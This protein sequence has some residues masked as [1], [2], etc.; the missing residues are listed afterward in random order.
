M[1]REPRIEMVGVTDD[2]RRK[3][4][5]GMAMSIAR[6]VLGKYGLAVDSAVRRKHLD[7]SVHRAQNPA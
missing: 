4:R 7:N 5:R 1:N 2:A 3:A 6:K